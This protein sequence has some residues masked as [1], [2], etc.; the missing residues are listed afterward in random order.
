[1]DLVYSAI[2]TINK[3]NIFLLYAFKDSSAPNAPNYFF[4]IIWVLVFWLICDTLS[5]YR[6]KIIL[7]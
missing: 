7:K 1:M 6:K 3:A 4:P 5:F 2:A